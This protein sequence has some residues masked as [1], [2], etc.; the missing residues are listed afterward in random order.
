VTVEAVTLRGDLVTL[1]PLSREDVPALRQL[2]GGSRGTF[3][4]AFVPTPEQVP[5]YVETALAQ[6]GRNAA[7]VFA[8]F[9][10]TE[11]VGCTRL[12]DLQRWEWM[13][14][15]DPRAGEDVL[16]AAEIGYTWLA[17]SAQRTAVNTEAKL[18][19]LE[20]AFETWRC[21]RVTLKTDERNLRSR[22]AIERLGAHFDGVLRAFQPAADGRPRNTAYYTI[23]ASEWPEVERGLRRRLQA[24]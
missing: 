6:M 2:A 24:R 8:I 16:D 5:A 21:H 17:E 15:T 4:W 22:R 3:Q 9:K 14:G 18:L 20:H 10:S 19:L 12:F 7:L 13:P 1:R 11:L 23:L